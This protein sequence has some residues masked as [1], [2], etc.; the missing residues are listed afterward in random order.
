M[1]HQPYYIR[2]AIATVAATVSVA[3]VGIYSK[4]S[5]FVVIAREHWH[6]NEFPKFTQWLAN[7]CWY[8]MLIPGCLL[9][10]GVFAVTRW[11]SKPAFEL[12]VGCLWLFALTW[13]MCGLF[14][15]LLPQVPYRE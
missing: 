2:L 4:L 5:I 8:A 12:A 11:R 3:F 13:L 15:W 6:F 7:L 10:A 9:M 14:V 1:K